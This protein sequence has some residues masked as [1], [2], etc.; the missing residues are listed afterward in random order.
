MAWP[1]GGDVRVLTALW[2]ALL[3][4]PLGF[5][6]A[7]EVRGSG[8]AFRP[9]VRIAAAAGAVL[10]TAGLT[11]AAGL[12]RNHWTELA[13]AAIAILLGFGAAS[14]EIRDPEKAIGPPRGR[15]ADR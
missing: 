7:Q 9:V 3:W 5:Y 11:Y 13:A 2:L 4:A 14:L 8:G 15:W 10:L 12:P 6:L 1:I